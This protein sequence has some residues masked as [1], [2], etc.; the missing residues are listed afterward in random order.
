VTAGNASGVNDGAAALI[1]ASE[2]AAKHGLTPIARIWAAPR[3]ACRRASW[4]SARPRRRRSCCARLGLKPA[5][6]T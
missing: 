4:A 2:A 1:I 3:P 5:T 6:S